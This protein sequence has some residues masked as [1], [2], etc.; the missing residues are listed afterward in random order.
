MTTTPENLALALR[1]QEQGAWQSAERVYRQ[2]LQVEP[3]HAEALGQLGLL[4][5]RQG[6]PDVAVGYL[7][8]ATAIDPGSAIIH[9]RLGQTYRALGRRQEALAAL[10]KATELKPDYAEAFDSL[11]TLLRE[12][13]R[14]PEAIA[15]YEQ[16]VRC[17]PHFAG[18]HCNLG[19]AYQTAGRLEEAL[20]RY[21]EALRLD[22]N[23]VP[24]YVNM[25]STLRS[26]GKLQEA[27]GCFCQAVRIQP[28]LPE[29]HY[30]LGIALHAQ[31]QEEEARSSLERALR[32]KL[33]ATEAA[34]R[35]TLRGNA[36]LP[37][38]HYELGMHLLL[39]GRFEEG[40]PE[41]EWRLRRRE[42]AP[43]FFRQP[44]WDGSPLRGTTILLHAEQGLGDTIQ[45]VRYAP[46]VKERGGRVVVECQ[47][48]LVQLLAR[49]PGI[50]EVVAAG[51]SLPSFEMYAPLLSLPGVFKT[52]EATIPA[53]VPY[54][55]A[56]GALDQ[57]WG[58]ELDAIPGFKVG[59]AWQGNPLHPKDRQ[60]SVPL[61][62]MAPLLGIPGV[63][64]FSLQV[65][66][67][68]E[69]LVTRHDRLDISDLGGRFDPSSFADAAAVI[70][71]LDLVI[72]VDS[73]LGH[74]A[75]AL[76]VPVWVALSF[77]PDWRW[78][79][80]REDSPWYPSA[81]LFRQTTPG[82]WSNVFARIAVELAK[83]AN[84]V[85]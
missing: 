49:T 53:T 30:N 21:K 54:V 42:P 55:F 78:Q 9:C 48:S 14:V 64:F 76:G 57:L 84:P 71:H 6:R 11:G 35:Q 8:Q 22:P 77:V 20:A 65:G 60:R 50:D 43:R 45:F 12:L 62:A 28:D 13:G 27:I 69:Q 51:S 34:Y 80:G 18:A 36:D 19:L 59:I 1:Y 17:S 79:L 61:E 2:I 58:R 63:R 25:G 85:T 38:V 68:R 41:F 47:G 3:R 67:G 81:R 29:H 75:A 72:T 23:F 37:A 46:L 40:W 10:S 15:C 39:M 44:C 73:A 4:A 83:R 7:V 70:K 31:G 24:A 56:D 26:Q 32:L 82:D 74:L 5:Y 52:T 16:A 66:P 33:D